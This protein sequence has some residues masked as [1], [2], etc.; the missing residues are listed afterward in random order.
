MYSCSYFRV[1]FLCLCLLL[2]VFATA[3]VVF[4]TALVCV[5]NCSCCVCNCSF[6][7]SLQ[8]CCVF[9][10]VFIVLL[11][12]FPPLLSALDFGSPIFRFFHRRVIECFLWTPVCCQVVWFRWWCDNAHVPWLVIPSLQYLVDTIPEVSE[13]SED[14]ILYSVEDF[15]FSRLYHVCM[16]VV[17]NE[18]EDDHF[19]TQCR[20][21]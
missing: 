2:F 14:D 17:G 19:A 7:V 4:A 8:P 13:L 20:M 9:L 6:L 16:R 11:G 1:L 18:V 12:L 15:V 21:V 3:L 10:E 5:C